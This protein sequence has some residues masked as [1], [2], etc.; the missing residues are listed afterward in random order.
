MK[1]LQRDRYGIGGIGTLIILIVVMLLLF[2]GI[3]VVQPMVMDQ[4]LS[5]GDTFTYSLEITGALEERGEVHYRIMS[6]TLS[7]ITLE[8]TNQNDV[9]SDHP[10]T[11]ERDGK[12]MVIEGVGDAGPFDFMM[13]VI[14][15]PGDFEK[16][17][18]YGLIGLTPMALDV[19]T[20]AVI[21]INITVKTKMG[22]AIPVEVEVV[23][24][25]VNVSYKLLDTNVCWISVPMVYL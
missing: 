20:G 18:S 5:P 24:P 13:G 14:N 21:G 16:S 4:K 19:Y 25:T 15:N 3:G 11:W 12:K 17:T 22:T 10:T 1:R 6:M 2:T 9:V 23:Y 8:V 7:N